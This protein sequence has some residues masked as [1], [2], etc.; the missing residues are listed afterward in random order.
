MAVQF[1]EKALMAYETMPFKQKSKVDHI[2]SQLHTTNNLQHLSPQ[3]LKNQD[4]GT[5][6]LRVDTTV[7][8][9]LIENDQ[10]F[11]IIDIIERGKGNYS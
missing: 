11:L 1:R 8:L 5:W 6:V 10:G 2:I 7:R 9:L 3:V 4:L